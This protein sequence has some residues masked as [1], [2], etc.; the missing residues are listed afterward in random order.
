MKSLQLVGA[1][2]PHLESATLLIVEGRDEPVIEL[3]EAAYAQRRRKKQLKIIPGAT[4][5]FVEPGTLEQVAQ[6]AAAW[7]KEQFAGAS[8]HGLWQ[9]VEISE[10]NLW[11]TPQWKQYEV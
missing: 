10:R 11:Q 6:L 8:K 3:N 9:C 5:L 7:F 4:H 1:A 2:L